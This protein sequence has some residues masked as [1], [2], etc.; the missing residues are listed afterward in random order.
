VTGFKRRKDERR[1]Q[2]LKKVAE[3]ARREKIEARAEQKQDR[4][5]KLGLTKE[6]L[7]IDDSE[8]EEEQ[9][10]RKKKKKTSTAHLTGLTGVK[11]ID[12][13]SGSVATV[14]VEAIEDLDDD[15]SSGN[16]ASSGDDSDDDGGRAKPL[17]NKG[18]KKK[19][20]AQ[21]KK[22]EQKIKKMYDSGA[23]KKL[24]GHGGKRRGKND[25]RKTGKPGKKG[26]R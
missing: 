22:E 3:D 19:T 18:Q 13:Q 25:A 21:I 20:A 10:Q 4:L 17:I 23:F 7:I 5:Q 14:T 2:A 15:D 1:K 6:D 12:L 16:E 9:E 11:Q 26:G 24:T 8:E